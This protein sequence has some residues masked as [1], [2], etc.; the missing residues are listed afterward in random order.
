MENALIA[1]R[2][3]AGLAT[4]AILACMAQLVHAQDNALEQMLKSHFTLTTTTADRS[5]IVT[6]GTVVILQ[7]SGL[8]MCDVAAKAP[9]PDTYKNGK[10][11]VS[12]GDRMV[13]GM[14]AA[15]SGTSIT[16]IPQR[17]FVAG[18]KF[19]ITG[20]SPE[21][22]GIFL[23]FYSDP[24]D[25]VRYYAQLR[26][27]YPKGA[28]PSADDVMKMIADVVTVDTSAPSTPPQPVPS[29]VPAQASEPALAPIAPPPPPADAP[30][31]APPT[32][33]IGQTKDQV[34]AIL[35]QPQRIAKGA[36]KEIDYYPD[37]KV[38]FV[39]G[40]VTDIQ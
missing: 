30:P 14:V 3:M 6:P 37:M 21:K 22:D 4:V 5:D 18:E 32:V 13:W 36:T 19:W 17:T 1:M 12:F 29:P 39:N 31:P 8:Q 35:G 9:L 23:H 11:S 28:H 16:D 24:Y 15:P 25:N 38:I 26:I 20:F 10:I 33:A 34:V 27:P 2:K 40:K 7:K